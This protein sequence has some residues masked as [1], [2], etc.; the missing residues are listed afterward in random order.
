MPDTDFV[1]V[2]HTHWDTPDNEGTEIL[3]VYASD[4]LDKARSDMRAA[5]AISREYPDDAWE[6]DYTWED[7]DMIH[8]GFDPQAVFEPATIYSWEITRLPVQ[9]R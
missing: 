8:L 3:G 9:R 5:D 6:D 4:A 7:D 2:L 1:Y